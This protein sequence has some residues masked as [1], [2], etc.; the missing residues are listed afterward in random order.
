MA[1]AG[2]S[3]SAVRAETGAR[4]I[5]SSQSR[6]APVAP[7]CKVRGAYGSVALKPRSTGFALFGGTD[8]G[9]LALLLR[10]DDRRSVMSSPNR[11]SVRAVEF[12]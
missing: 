4:V 5:A 8:S 7:T 3:R 12:G 10:Q 6:H 2:S 1:Q 11:R 9:S